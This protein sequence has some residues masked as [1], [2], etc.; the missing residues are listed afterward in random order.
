MIKTSQWNRTDAISLPNQNIIG[1]INIELQ[2]NF[3]VHFG[4]IEFGNWIFVSDFCFGNVF[5]NFWL[6]LDANGEIRLFLRITFP[7]Y[8]LRRTTIMWWS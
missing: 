2:L 7:S 8:V 3:A 4:N 6:L 5:L 1:Q